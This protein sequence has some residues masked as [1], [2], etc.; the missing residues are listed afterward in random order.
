MSTLKSIWAVLA[1]LIFVFGITT[2]TDQI[3]EKTGF[4]ALPFASNP[5]WLMILVTVYRQVYVAVGAYITAW[6][7][8]QRPMLHAMIL[9]G[10]GF[11][12]GTLGAV[13][14]WAEPPHW[15]PI[16]LV[17]L[18]VPSAWIGAKMFLSRSSVATA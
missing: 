12:L 4:M 6:L 10:I 7:A 15:Y 13:V 3:L 8:P 9:A 18:G 17:I 2:A 1:G 14:M 16:A 11:V 5:L